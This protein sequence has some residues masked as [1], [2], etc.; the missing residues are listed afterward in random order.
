MLEEAACLGARIQQNTEAIADELHA[1]V[2][3]I[4]RPQR[5]TR[6]ARILKRLNITPGSAFDIAT[7]DEDGQPWGFDLEAR[8]EK[9]IYLFIQ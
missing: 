7:H 8:Q 2:S 6:A 9:A 1:V 4:Y 3:E 5:V